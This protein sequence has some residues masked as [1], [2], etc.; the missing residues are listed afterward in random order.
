MF[1]HLTKEL[2]ITLQPSY[3]GDDANVSLTE[4]WQTQWVDICVK[5]SQYDALRQ[6]VPV[7]NVVLP[8]DVIHEA[9]VDATKIDV[10]HW[11]EVVLTSVIRLEKSQNSV[12]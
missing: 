11:V 8:G 3:S 5:N 6:M 10:D 2:P 9:E 1:V 7:E 12:H 4:G